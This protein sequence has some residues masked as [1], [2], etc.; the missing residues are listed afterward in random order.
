MDPNQ[1]FLPKVKGVPNEDGSIL[2]PPIEEMSPLISKKELKEEMIVEL[3]KKSN[4]IKR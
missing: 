3:S 2:S 4:Q 1:G